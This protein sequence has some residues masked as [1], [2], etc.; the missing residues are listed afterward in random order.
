MSQA[1]RCPKITEPRGEVATQVGVLVGVAPVVLVM[2]QLSGLT[3]RSHFLLQASENLVSSGLLTVQVHDFASLHC[4][5]IGSTL[6]CR[7][8]HTAFLL[9]VVLVS[10]HVMMSCGIFR[11]VYETMS[12]AGL[13]GSFLLSP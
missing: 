4:L 11:G 3:T 10:P 7:F 1:L 13:P 8:W 9:S 5:A 6:A 12:F 2:S